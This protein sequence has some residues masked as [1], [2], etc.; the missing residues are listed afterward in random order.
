MYHD[1]TCY[2]NIF[3][4]ENM[5]NDLLIDTLSVAKENYWLLCTSHPMD[6]SKHQSAEQLLAL[7]KTSIEVSLLNDILIRLI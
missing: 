2:D 4:I 7:E 1:I 5:F 3:E 6:M